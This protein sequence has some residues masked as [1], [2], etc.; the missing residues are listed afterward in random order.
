MAASGLCNTAV[1]TTNFGKSSAEAAARAVALIGATVPT[2]RSPP[3]SGTCSGYPK[4]TWQNLVGNP[5]DGERDI[6]DVSLFAADGHLGPLLCD[7]LFRRLGRRRALHGRAEQLG[8]R[9]RHVLLVAD[10]GRHPGADRSEAERAAG[11][12]PTR[13]YMRLA[14]T[15]YGAS[16]NAPLQFDAGKAGRVDLRLLRRH[17]RRQRR[18]L[19][20]RCRTWDCP[21]SGLTY[22]GP[23]NCYQRVAATWACCRRPTPLMRRPMPQPTGWDFATGIGT[24]NAYNLVHAWP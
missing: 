4:P 24:I 20:L 11:A 10:H 21:W 9:R 19:H 3:S 13:R 1:G 5:S 23:V 16:G 12:I 22:T 6:P 8:G 7:L 15:E 14:K 2:K 18:E 17:A